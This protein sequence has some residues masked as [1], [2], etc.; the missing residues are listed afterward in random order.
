MVRDMKKHFIYLFVLPALLPMICL[1]DY[2]PGNEL[3]Y[4]SIAD[5][6]LRNG[7]FFAFTNQGLPYADKPPL[8]FWLIMLAKSLAGKHVLWLLSLFSLLPAWVVVRTMNRWAGPEIYKEYQPTATWMMLSCGLFLGIAL[9][10]RP[11]MM[12]CMF[13]IL[14]LHTFYRM[15]KKEGNPRRNAVLFPAYIFLGLLTKGLV[16]LLIPLLSTSVFLLF[17]KRIRSIGRYWGWKTWGIL[18]GGC[19]LWLGCVYLEGGSGYLNN[20]LFHQTVDRAVNAFH[21]KEAFY[22]YALT[23]WYSML[24]WSL[25]IIGV[26]VTAL[27]RKQFHSELQK[28]FL[29]V[30]GV[31]FVLLSCISS[32]IEV[33]LIPAYPFFV[34]LAAMQLSRFK[35]NPWLAL[36]VAI[37]ALAF[38]GTVPALI[39]LGGRESTHILAHGFLYAAAGVLT[40]S[41]VN[42]LCNLYYWKALDKSINTLA[43]GLFCA[44]FIGGFALPELNNQFGYGDLCRKTKVTAKELGVSE[45]GA[46]EIH[47]A[48]N[49]DV[50]LGKDV[51]I[52]TKEEL[53]SGR[54]QGMVLMFPMRKLD[55]IREVV[56]EKDIRVVG[57]YGFALLPFN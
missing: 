38:C 36:T 19:A 50:F 39:W 51:R 13:I 2:T 27:C 8:Y 24:P 41:G 49:M 53:L 14:S 37:P 3:R 16:A 45:Y 25:L 7:T 55:T 23:M 44:L 32:K 28:F 47:R 34:Y 46:Y 21:H 48:E 5:E 22:Y 1:R 15:L 29:T 18:L 54:L 17:T 33:Y 4:L 12:M 56:S 43:F 26:V 42:A 9:F 35:W 31:T 10:L 40:L 52:L 6:A 11:D 30:S 57:Y 20:L